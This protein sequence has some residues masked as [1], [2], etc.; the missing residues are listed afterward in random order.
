MMMSTIV[1]RHL[2]SKERRNCFQ[3]KHPFTIKHFR[4]ENFFNSILKFP[5]EDCLFFW[6]D[7]T[8]G[9]G[10]YFGTEFK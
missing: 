10:I 7:F 3:R 2:A 9:G 6:P 5:T 1:W 8:S 4:F